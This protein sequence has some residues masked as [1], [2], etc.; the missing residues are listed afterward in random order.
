[1]Y[2]W[3]GETVGKSEITATDKKYRFATRRNCSY[4]PFG[5]KVTTLYFPV[6]MELSL[7]LNSFAKSFPS[8]GSPAPST[9]LRAVG[10]ALF[11]R[12]RSTIVGLRSS[13]AA[14]VVGAIFRAIDLPRDRPRA[15]A[16]AARSREQF[17]AVGNDRSFDRFALAMRLASR[18]V[19]VE[20][21]RRESTSVSID[22]AMSR[23]RAAASRDARGRL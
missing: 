1:V 4:S 5:A 9:N 21:A 13:A 16:C 20:D 19:R 10:F 12:K 17:L 7:H 23:A 18:R 6:Q 8:F 3:I 11:R 22:G 2:G 15:R 14:A